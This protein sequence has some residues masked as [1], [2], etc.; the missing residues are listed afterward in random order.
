MDFSKISR[1]ELGC[2][3][4]AT[5]YPAI[6]TYHEMGERGCLNETRTEVF[7][8]GEE[9]VVTEK[10]DGT[11]SRII[12]SPYGDYIIGSREDLL[13]Y[14]GDLLFNTAQ[15]IVE[16]A[17]HTAVYLHGNWTAEHDDCLW[18]FYGEVY[19]GNVGN[20]AKQYT[21]QRA[22][23]YRLFDVALFPIKELPELL[24]QGRK[25]ISSWRQHGGQTFLDEE[26]LQQAQKAIDVPL[27]PRL[28]VTEP[29]PESI[30]EASQWLKGVLPEEGTHCALD[31]GAKGR[32]EGIVIRTADRKKIVKLR[33]QDYRKTLEKR[34]AR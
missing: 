27:T 14:R 10:V 33:F 12:S 22:T 28:K 6:L 32:S 7:E 23:G 19:G 16:A 17:R 5:K 13:T 20:S 2:L 21:S 29:L 15:G 18:V 11:N 31:E 24:A 9:L 4:S 30:E 25:K 8:P 26:S 34:K 1:E 3:N